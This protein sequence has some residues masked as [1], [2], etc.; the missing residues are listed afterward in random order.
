MEG[1][2]AMLLPVD[3]TDDLPPMEP[4]ED[5]PEESEK[6]DSKEG[7]DNDSKKWQHHRPFIKGNTIQAK[8][9]WIILDAKLAAKPHLPRVQQ[10]PEVPFHA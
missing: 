3:Y 6:E 10:P 2:V 5:F 9:A 1:G 8:V 7:E 4:F